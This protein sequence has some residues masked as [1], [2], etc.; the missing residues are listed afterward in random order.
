MLPPWQS[1]AAVL[2]SPWTFWRRRREQDEQREVRLVPQQLNT[3]HSDLIWESMKVELLLPGA[4]LAS[5]AT[6][7]M[8][9]ASLATAYI[10]PPSA[11]WSLQVA[12]LLLL[13]WESCFD[14][15]CIGSWVAPSIPSPSLLYHVQHA[16]PCWL[17]ICY[18][19]PELYGQIYTNNK[20]MVIGPLYGL[21]MAP[22]LDQWKLW[23][24]SC[25]Q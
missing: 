24:P 6:N 9:I 15:Y 20:A 8:L 11:L 23:Y 21:Y 19:S 12:S 25:D 2:G 5:P 10:A 3:G 18:C 14:G 4:L 7:S 16:L 22:K 13:T 1:L 17:E